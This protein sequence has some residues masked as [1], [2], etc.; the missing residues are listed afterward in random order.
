[1]YFPGLSKPQNRL[2]ETGLMLRLMLC[3]N[4]VFRLPET[5]RAIEVLTGMAWVT[6]NN[7]DIF[8]AAGE[9]HML[10]SRRDLVLISALGQPP[11]ILEVSGATF[12]AGLI[13]GGPARQAR[14]PPADEAVD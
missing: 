3:Q 2:N 7:E 14:S 1:M 12:Q 5:S 9:R 6:V 4:E 10:P 13:K 11:L 8:L